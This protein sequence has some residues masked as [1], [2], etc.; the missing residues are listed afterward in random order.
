MPRCLNKLILEQPKI[1]RFFHLIGCV[2][3][4]IVEQ[5]NASLFKWAHP[6]TTAVVRISSTYN[7]LSYLRLNSFWVRGSNFCLSDCYLCWCSGS[8]WGGEPPL[9]EVHG[10]HPHLLRARLL[11]FHRHQ[12]V[13]LFLF[14]HRE[15]SSCDGDGCDTVCYTVCM[16]RVSR[17]LKIS[18]EKNKW[19]STD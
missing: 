19:V 4:L 6:R 18:R 11:R 15:R 16:S 14:F 8:L 10:P 5:P 2:N 12:Q 17:I 9:S 13:S 1:L 3:R 7:L